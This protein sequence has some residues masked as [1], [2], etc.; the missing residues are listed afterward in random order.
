M[1]PTASAKRQRETAGGADGANG[2]PASLGVV[3]S[4]PLSPGRGWR[5]RPTATRERQT[6]T[7]EE[8]G[9]RR[10]VFRASNYVRPEGETADQAAD[11]N[12]SPASLGSVRGQPLALGAVGEN[13]QPRNTR[14]RHCANSPGSQGCRSSAKPRSPAS[15]GFA[16]WLPLSPG[17]VREESL[18]TLGKGTE[19]RRSRSSQ[20]SR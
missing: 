13:A 8:A 10:G 4:P 7:E 2:S 9:A 16:S 20:G 14:G 19:S 6:A 18:A 15:L 11:A 12:G 5:K 17:E 1:R 3:R